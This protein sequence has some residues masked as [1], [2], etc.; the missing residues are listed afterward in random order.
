MLQLPLDLSA[1]GLILVR[2]SSGISFL[3][4]NL[5]VDQFT[6][7]LNHL[8]FGLPSLPAS[9]SVIMDEPELPVILQLLTLLRTSV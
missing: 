5:I 1:G 2:C 4:R 9:P 3:C 7:A 8:N 6:S